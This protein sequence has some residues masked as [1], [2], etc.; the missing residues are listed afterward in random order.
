TQLQ[1]CAVQIWKPY[2]RHVPDGSG[3][4]CDPCRGGRPMIGLGEDWR[5]RQSRFSAEK[6]VVDCLGGF[7]VVENETC[8]ILGRCRREMTWFPVAGSKDGPTGAT[9]Y[10]VTYELG[11]TGWGKAGLATTSGSTTL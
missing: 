9:L 10:R 8:R 7:L 3:A 1:R 2:T 5:S 4:R 11:G 6:R